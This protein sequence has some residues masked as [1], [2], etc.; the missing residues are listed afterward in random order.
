MG[1]TGIRKLSGS[2]PRSFNPRARDGRDCAIVQCHR[3]NDV[4]IHAPVMGA[5]DAQIKEIIAYFVSIHAPVMGAT[6]TAGLF[7]TK[8]YLCFNPRA[9]DGRDLSYVAKSISDVKFQSTRP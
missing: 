4:S 3:L 7:S 9:R 2:P 5:T 8:H 1:A 6:R